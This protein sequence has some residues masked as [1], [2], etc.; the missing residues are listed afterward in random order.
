MAKENRFKK[1]LDKDKT[2]EIVGNSI[3]NE[4]ISVNEP[5]E[6][7]KNMSVDENI[8][9]VK[10]DATPIKKSK[11]VTPSKKLKDAPVE[12]PKFSKVGVTVKESIRTKVNVLAEDNNMK[13]NEVVV[14]LLKRVFDGKNFTIDIDKKDE[15]KVTSFNIPDEMSKALI[16]LNKSTGITKSEIFNKLLEEALQDFF[17]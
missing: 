10:E 8:N 14:D 4:D 5:E 3:I 16:K 11:K 12:K 6:D 17:E 1:N 15:I 9:E 7:V 2:K 13:P